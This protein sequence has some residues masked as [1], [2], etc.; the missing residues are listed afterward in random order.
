[1]EGKGKLFTGSFEMTFQY[2]LFPDHRQANVYIFYLFFNNSV[3]NGKRYTW[4]EI[5]MLIINTTAN[6]VVKTAPNPIF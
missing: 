6:I 1:M 2:C 4:E 5:N 3:P